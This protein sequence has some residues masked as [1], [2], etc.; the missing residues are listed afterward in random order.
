MNILLTKTVNKMTLQMSKQYIVHGNDL[1][2][3]LSHLNNRQAY[4]SF[5]GPPCI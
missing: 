3:L 5:I 2:G 1:C 4:L